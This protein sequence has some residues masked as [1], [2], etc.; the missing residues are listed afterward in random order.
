MLEYT[1]NLKTV[2]GI[3]YIILFTM[4]K[5]YAL[6]AR[7]ND[8]SFTVTD[9]VNVNFVLNCTSQGGPVNQMLWQYDSQQSPIQNSNPFP[10]LADESMGLYFSILTVYG[11]INGTYRCSITN[12]FNDTHMEKEYTVDGKYS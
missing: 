4:T 1:L 10:L 11:R 8:I 2:S 7:L 3:D 5:S 6:G 9:E 12:E